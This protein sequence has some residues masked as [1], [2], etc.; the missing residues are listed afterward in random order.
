MHKVTKELMI[1][2]IQR[3]I[4]AI[5]WEKT[6]QYIL[7]KKIPFEHLHIAEVGCGTGTFS[8]T[9]GLLGAEVVLI[10]IDPQAIEMAKDAFSIFKCD[11]AFIQMSVLDPVPEFLTKRFD[12]VISGGLAEH[13]V[14]DDRLKCIAFHEAL[15]R[16][17][18]FS[19]IGVPNKLSP[20]YQ[21]VRLFRIA[22]RTW[23]M[24]IE[25]PYTYWELIRLAKEAGFREFEVRG[26]HSLRKDLVDYS[27]G[28]ISAILDILPNRVRRTLRSIKT[29][30]SIPKNHDYY[31][32]KMI[33]DRIEKI[34]DK[35]WTISKRLFKD[36]F[37]A[38]II[39]LGHKGSCNVDSGEAS[40]RI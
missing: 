28:M 11:A 22:T 10:D 30:E 17:G 23:K 38:G 14:G 8:L 18:G 36:F 3:T 19:F 26:N 4:S 16:E 27:L 40:I 33:L 31:A 34:D 7:K 12:L 24:E 35:P 20:F 1:S 5:G 13:F 6:A 9:F 25:I 29:K 39:L 21:A 37:S 15:L 32:K 2:R